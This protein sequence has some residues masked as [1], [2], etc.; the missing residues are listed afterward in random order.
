MDR[1]IRKAKLQD[2][3]Q[4]NKLVFGY[5]KN[6]KML[7]RPLSY[8]APRIRDF[9]VCVIGD[10][11]V[12]CV[13]LR[14]WNM[15]WA[16]IMALAVSPEYRGSGIGPKL[17]EAC[18]NEAK[19]LGIKRVLMLTFEHSLAEKSGFQKLDSADTLPEIIFTEKTVIIDKVYV[20]ELKN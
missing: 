15:Q 2:A 1:E 18:L 16:E 8:I 9:F 5:A 10:K 3:K 7:S 11:I 6:G 19:I 20:L 17:V 4:I 12:G 14:V 13:G